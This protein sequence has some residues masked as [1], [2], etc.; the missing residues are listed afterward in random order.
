MFQIKFM[1]ML[2]Y[3]PSYKLDKVITLLEKF[4]QSNRLAFLLIECNKHDNTIKADVIATISS[5]PDRMANKLKQNNRYVLM[6]LK[7]FNINEN[8]LCNSFSGLDYL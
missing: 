3:R 6:V 5:F 7:L 2:Y 4:I 1:R 8:T